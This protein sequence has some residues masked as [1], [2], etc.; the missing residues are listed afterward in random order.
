MMARPKGNDWLESDIRKLHIHGVNVVV[1]LLETSEIRELG[2]SEEETLCQSHDIEYIHH[3]I[4]DRGVPDSHGKFDSLVLDLNAKLRQDRK[5][6]VHCRMGI[7]RTSLIC[8]ALLPKNGINLKAVFE[9]LS[10][11]RTLKVPDT[12]DQ[13]SW[14]CNYYS[15]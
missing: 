1:S 5:V 6:V 2:L 12:T 7:G 8:A 9:L 11:T 4:P 13:V 14:I 10:E 15:Q 3:P